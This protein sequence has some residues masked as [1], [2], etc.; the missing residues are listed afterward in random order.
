MKHKKLVGFAAAAALVMAA[1]G[2]DDSSSDTTAAPTDDTTAAVGT[3]L[4]DVCPAKIVLQTDWN[5]EAEHGFLYE[6]IGAGYEVDTEKLAVRGDLV[7]EG[8]T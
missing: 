7:S 1:C 8:Q 4:A 2:G 3:N 6:M 5:P